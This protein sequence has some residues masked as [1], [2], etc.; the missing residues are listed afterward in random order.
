[1][2]PQISVAPASYLPTLDARSASCHLCPDKHQSTTVDSS[3]GVYCFQ[4]GIRELCILHASASWEV[5]SSG[6]P[7]LLLAWA[8]TEEVS[9]FCECSSW[10]F[11]HVLT[12]TAHLSVALQS[13]SWRRPP[14]PKRS[15]S[16]I[17]VL[18]VLFGLSCEVETSLHCITS[19]FWW[20]GDAV[21]R[22]HDGIVTYWHDDM[23]TYW[24]DDMVTWASFSWGVSAV[25]AGPGDHWEPER[26][27]PWQTVDQSQTMACIG[28]Y[29]CTYVRMYVCTYVCI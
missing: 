9:C 4:T 28:K 18:H 1:M 16:F 26:L 2:S 17:N 6:R 23:V 14:W 19:T 15:V 27:V 3:V 20:H 7:S 22:C 10:R 21:T 24:H 13:T 29:V 25:H 8:A 11:H 12:V 5:P